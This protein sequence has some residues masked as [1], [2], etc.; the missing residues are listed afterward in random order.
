MTAIARHL[1]AELPLRLDTRIVELKRVAGCWKLVDAAGH[2]LGP[3]EQLIVSLPAPQTA[4]LLA[5]HPLAAEARA[6]PMSPC[7][8]VLVAFETAL[9]VSWDGA[10]VHDSA[11]AW[12][13]RNSSKPGRDAAR[14]CWVL[15]AAPEWSATNRESPRAWVA[16]TLLAELA[17]LS[18]RP[19]PP[20]LYLE[21]HRWLYSAPVPSLDRLALFDPATGLAVCGDW[22]A[23]GRMEGAWLSGQAA[24]ACLLGQPGN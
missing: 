2:E 15:H 8:A 19:L 14:D 1:A 17:G 3:F 12:M 18:G 13:A 9:E 24:A 16:T 4:E 11:L 21:A 5:D 6:V 7:W 23:G 10:F 22:L 20:T